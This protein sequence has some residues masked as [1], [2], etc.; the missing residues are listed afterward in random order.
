MASTAAT[1]EPVGERRV[2]LPDATDARPVSVYRRDGL[3]PGASW[4][5]P[6]LVAEVF[7]N[8]YVTEAGAEAAYGLRANPER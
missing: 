2:R 7:R 6:A 4:V 5:G 1:P 8:G 3:A